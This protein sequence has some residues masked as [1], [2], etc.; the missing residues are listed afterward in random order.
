[1]SG[2]CAIIIKGESKLL[3]SNWPVSGRRGYRQKGK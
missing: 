1:M 2:W 3:Q